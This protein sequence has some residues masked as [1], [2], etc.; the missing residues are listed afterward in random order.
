MTQTSGMTVRETIESLDLSVSSPLAC[1][2]EAVTMSNRVSENVF[3]CVEEVFSNVLS[4]GFST[5]LAPDGFG[6]HF[7]VESLS[8]SAE[9]LCQSYRTNFTDVIV[10]DARIPLVYV[11]GEL[12]A[13]SLSQEIATIYQET[14]NCTDAKTTLMVVDTT[15]LSLALLAHQLGYKVVLE[16]SEEQL[17]NA[18]E[19]IVESL[20]VINCA[21]DFPYDASD[22]ANILSNFYRANLT[23]TFNYRILKRDATTFVRVLSAKLEGMGGSINDLTVGTV[24]SLFSK[25]VARLMS[26]DDGTSSTFADLLKKY[27]HIL[28]AEMQKMDIEE[29]IL[30]FSSGVSGAPMSR[31]AIASASLRA[32]SE[33]GSDAFLGLIEKIEAGIG[34]GAPHDDSLKSAEDVSSQQKNVVSAMSSVSDVDGELRDAIFGQDKALDEIVSTLSLPMAGFVYPD[35]PLRS[36]L[37]VGPTGVGKTETAKV[38]ANSMMNE[39]MNIIRLDMSEYQEK[40]SAARLFGSPIGYEGSNEGGILT[41]GVINNPRSLILIDEIEK[42][43]HSVWDAFLQVLDSAR[44]TDGMG[45]VADFSQCVVIMTSNI[46]AE[47]TESRIAGFGTPH[48]DTDK[49]QR[50]VINEVKKSMR[51]EFFNRIDKVVVF[52]RLTKES[53]FPIIER[54]MDIYSETLYDTRGVEIGYS[55]KEDVIRYFLEI[56]DPQT[57]GAREVKRVIESHMLVP[58]SRVVTMMTAEDAGSKV[59]VGLDRKSNNIKAGLVKSRKKPRR[60]AQTRA[61]TA[62]S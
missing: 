4:T 15:D 42:A 3:T 35:K 17:V 21:R 62:T 22:I 59:V 46:G 60:A 30:V 27:H 45:N 33:E 25:T 57:F 56:I 39:P 24:I 38:I 51:S 10:I 48:L 16:C 61:A 34:I 13:V 54:Q 6:K 44:M 49:Q 14:R 26:Y 55:N 8:L 9:N 36:M 37:F 28:D 23:N 40:Q 47:R 2:K 58:L 52:Q 50:D 1:R 18:P 32:N 19:H 43:H 31:S 53:I 5:L 11:Q 7:I 12:P 20:N 29:S 41:R